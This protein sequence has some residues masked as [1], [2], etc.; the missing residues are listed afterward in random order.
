MSIINKLDKLWSKPAFNQNSRLRIT[1][2]EDI[3]RMKFCVSGV[4]RGSEGSEGSRAMTLAFSNLFL[5]L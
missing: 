2:D 1:S 3:N 4:C 5:K